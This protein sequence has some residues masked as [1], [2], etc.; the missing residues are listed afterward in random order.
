MSELKSSI[1][2]LRPLK[3]EAETRTFTDPE[4]PGWSLTM[5]LRPLDGVSGTRYAVLKGQ[6]MVRHVTGLRGPDGMLVKGEDGEPLQKPV[7]VICGD[8]SKRTPD[9]YCV[10]RYAKIAAMWAV[11]GEEPPP[12]SEVVGWQ[13]L[14]Y[15]AWFDICNWV[16][17]LYRRES[18]E[19][20]GAT[21]TSSAA[22]SS[23]TT[24]TPKSPPDETPSSAPSN[25]GSGSS[26]A[27]SDVPGLPATLT[28]TAGDRRAPTEWA[29]PR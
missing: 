28:A 17:S 5:T 15:E 25:G 3:R 2:N 29:A 11:E 27:S 6:L 14:L 8:F 10:D 23:D 24:S 16:E 13:A 26:S 20:G 9:E 1:W 19:K 12:L 18:E 21:A 4:Q 22:S 7:P